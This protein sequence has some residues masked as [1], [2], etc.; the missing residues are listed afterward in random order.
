MTTNINPNSNTNHKPESLLSRIIKLGLPVA[1]QSALVAI[2]A[3]ADVLMVSDFGM[4]AAAAVGIASKWHFVAIMIMAGL[5]SANGTLVAQ[6]WGKSDRKSA[7]TVTSIAMTFGLKVLVPVTL[8]ITL[9]AK[10][11]MTLQT[12]DQSVI[13][14]GAT[15]L[16]YGFPVLLLT[17]IV[18]VTEASM[19]SSGDTVTPLIL[20]AVTIALNIALNFVLIQGAFGLPAMGVAGAA[21]ATTLARLIQVGMMYLYMRYKQHWLLTTE[22]SMQRPS[23]W[24]SY[25][26]LALPLTLNAVL[27]AIGTMAYQMIFGHMGTTELAVF[28]M[29][30]PFESLCYSVFFGISVACSVLLGHS[31]GRDEFDQAMRMGLTFIKTVVGFGALVGFMLFMGKEHVLTW[32]NLD[33]AALYPL[34]SPA[35]TIMCFAVVIRML[36]MVIIN[37]IIRAGGDNRFCL[38][39]DFI[40]MWMVGIP[41]CF[42]GAFIAGWDFKYIYGLMLVEEVVKLAICS[43]R[44]M[45]RRWINNLTISTEEPQAA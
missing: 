11:L 9:G 41:V 35:M 26:R 24:L 19:R 15:Y 16:W 1:L 42:Y 31:L 27:W 17:H 22:S 33:E 14:L 7:R 2:L 45:S 32:L 28:S 25:R 5:A 23:L 29:L 44:Y 36:N 12:S 30:A 38:R 18:I 34:A 20:G 8:V 13:D 21:L 43:H 40:A 3:L 10:L 4:E 37:G 6:Y 39:M